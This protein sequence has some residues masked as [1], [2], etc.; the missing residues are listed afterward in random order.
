MDGDETAQL[1]LR[2]LMWLLHSERAG[3]R[4]SRGR[5]GNRVLTDGRAAGRRA[6]RRAGAPHRRWRDGPRRVRRVGGGAGRATD[7]GGQREGRHPPRA[8]R[9]PHGPGPRPRRRLVGCDRERNRPRFVRS[10]P[11]TVVDHGRGAT[12]RCEDRAGRGAARHG[13]CAAEEHLGAGPAVRRAPGAVIRRRLTSPSAQSCAAPAALRAG[14]RLPQRRPPARRAV[15]SRGR[16]AARCAARRQ[17]AGRA[18]RAR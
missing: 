14:R 18:A 16:A 6:R 2:G 5:G 15:L 13:L 9:D 8:R 11:G 12:G 1:P 10:N 7:G 3:R 4:R 17:A